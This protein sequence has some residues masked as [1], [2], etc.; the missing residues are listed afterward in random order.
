M[1]GNNSGV[2]VSHRALIEHAKTMAGIAARIEENESVSSEDLSEWQTEADASSF[3][4]RRF[5]AA[6]GGMVGFRLPGAMTDR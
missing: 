1:V 4:F 5:A 3:E 6:I 2:A